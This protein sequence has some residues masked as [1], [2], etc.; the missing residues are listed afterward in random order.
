MP[1][2]HQLDWRRQEQPVL[3]S[4]TTRQ[5]WCRVQLYSPSVVKVG[6]TYRMWFLGNDT[7]TRTGEMDLGYAESPDGLIWTE[8]P[9]NP[10]LTASDLPYGTMWQ[11]PH[12]LFDEQLG[13]LRMWFTMYAV[14]RD[15]EGMR[16]STTRVGHATSEDGLRWDIH[17]HPLLSDGRGPCVLK[18][19]DARY[20]MWM[21]ATPPG[22]TDRKAPCKNI[23]RFAST[24]GLDWKRDADPAIFTREDR[25]LVYPF[26]LHDEHGSTMWYGRTACKGIFEVYCSTSTDGLHWTHHYDQAALAAT[27]DPNTFD[28]RYI[29]TPCVVDDGDRYLMYYSARDLGNLY[30]AGDGTIRS[31]KAGIYRHIGVA[32]A[33]R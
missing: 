26:V 11:T 30:G 31:D 8:H 2:L 12:V 32:V 17:P 1:L 19:D 33:E 23:Y 25:I 29:S 10:I 14:G 4:M 16:I 13:I 24:D 21:G 9:D 28:G 5:P 15:D 22:D 3:S 20:R 7:A 6:D 27:R 18:D